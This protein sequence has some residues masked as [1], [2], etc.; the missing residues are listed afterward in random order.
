MIGDRGLAIGL[1]AALGA[2][3]IDCVPS[4]WIKPGDPWALSTALAILLTA[5]LAAGYLPAWKA[6]KTTPCSRFVLSDCRS[7]GC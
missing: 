2:I 3:E 7:C 4:F 5:A 6:S 1:P